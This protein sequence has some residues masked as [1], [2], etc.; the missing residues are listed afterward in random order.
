MRGRR[1]LLLIVLLTLVALPGCAPAR[2]PY[3]GI[4]AVQY[5]IPEPD[6]VSSSLLPPPRQISDPRLDDIEARIAALPY[7]HRPL[8]YADYGIEAMYLGDMVK[9]ERFL[10]AAI[11]AMSSITTGDAS[12]A[13]SM[14][15]SE[16]DKLYKGEP[17][18]RALV[19]LYR[20]L[21]YIAQGE[22]DNAQACF[23]A[24]ALADAMAEHAED[25]CDWMTLDVM[26]LQSKRL[27]GFTD[28][29]D[30]RTSVEKKYGSA[31]PPGWDSAFREP[32]FIMAASGRAPLK[33]PMRNRDMP[34]KLGYVEARSEVSAVRVR[35][36]G[37][38]GTEI[39]LP[40][41]DDVYVQ[42]ASRGTRNMDAV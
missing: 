21:L 6:A 25:R 5:A 7:N 31:L 23:V 32:V 17:H 24:G 41:A 37:K 22:P 39:P 8:L 1:S 26:A 42:A 35:Q 13:T 40:L 33:V 3:A 9:A 10:D 15:G 38:E 30:W 20:G 11:A 18:E 27:A 2:N 4:S 34:M 36:G 28:A 14:K 12:A 19:Y 29:D 16:A